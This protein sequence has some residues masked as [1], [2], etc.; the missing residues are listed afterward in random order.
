[1]HHENSLARHRQALDEAASGHEDEA[2]KL[3]AMAEIMVRG[4]RPELAGDLRSMVQ[5]CRVEAM[6]LLAL[7]KGLR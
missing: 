2:A 3:S 7:A 5:R 4:P 1:M 6:K